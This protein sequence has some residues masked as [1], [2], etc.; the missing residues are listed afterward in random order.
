M[1]RNA[2]K[3]GRAVE[4]K[5]NG[6]DKLTLTVT[7]RAARDQ[8]QVVIEDDGIGLVRT[9]GDGQGMALHSTMVAIAGGSLAVESIPGR[10]TRATLL[11]PLGEDGKILGE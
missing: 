4:S 8:L 6:Q 1:I 2:A 5:E 11:M 7:M 9:N 3:H 10:M